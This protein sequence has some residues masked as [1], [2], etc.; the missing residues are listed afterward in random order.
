MDRSAAWAIEKMAN[1]KQK[2][3]GVAVSVAGGEPM[4]FSLQRIYSSCFTGSNQK[5]RH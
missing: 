1:S 3:Y 4:E 2:K 5:G